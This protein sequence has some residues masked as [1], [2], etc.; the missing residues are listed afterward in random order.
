MTTVSTAASPGGRIAVVI[1][2]RPEMIK[3][4]PI[5]HRLGERGTLIHTG[6]HFDPEMS[7]I[8]L[9]QFSL[10]E[11]DRHLDVGGSSRGEQIGRSLIDIERLLLTERFDAVVVQGDTNS[12]LA[13][14]LAAN[15]TGTPLVH[16]EAGL[17]S[18]D[19]R[20]PEE[21][22][23]V[24]LDAIADLCLAP[25]PSNAEQLRS[26]GIPAER[27]AITGSTLLESVTKMLPAKEQRAALM[28]RLGVDARFV[29]ATIHRAE[30]TDDP[31]RL[32][33]IL[34]AI[35]TL[36]VQVLVPLHP[37]T[38]E[39][40]RRFGLEQLLRPMTV[41]APLGYVEFI[42]AASQCDLIIS[43]SGGVQEEATIVKRPVVIV[44]ESTE[45]PE[46]V[47][48]FAHLESDG[49][50]VASVARELLGRID[51]VHA[52]LEARDYPYG[53][54]A[55]DRCVEEIERLISRRG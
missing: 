14:G 17:R 38:A 3:M 31:G 30:N 50:G 24:L 12:S 45:R 53:A 18:F 16:V 26:E 1:G 19:R 52:D 23:R 33:E 20:M 42:A 37:R 54:G 7:R 27:I 35:G 41:V 48:T 21:H 9:D 36:P 15:S 22:N 8:F 28:R 47:G 4:A 51:A 44:R 32:R 46:I 43:D 34:G 29:L 10:G 49:E 40:V 13:G 6:Q 55:A 2:T 5:L 25:H 11:P 39:R